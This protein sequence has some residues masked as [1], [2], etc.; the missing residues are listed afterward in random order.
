MRF[1]KGFAVALCFGLLACSD[2]VPSGDPQSGLKRDMRGYKASPGVLVAED[3]TPHWIQSAVT[4]YK[5]TTLDTDLPAKVVMQQPTAFC[6]FRKPNLG[7]YIGNVHVGT[8][9]MHAPIYTW[10]KTKIR[11][12]AQKL[13]E[14][15]QKPAD[16]PRKIR[17]DTMVLS[18]KD[19][20]FPV[21]DV[22]VTET[23][24]P[25][26]LILQNEFGKILWNIHL[27][28]GARISHVVALGVGDIAFAN[29]DPDVPV[30]MA[31]AR[32]L[33]SCGVQPWRKMQDHWLFA[34][35]AKENPSLHE[36][37]VAKNKAAYRKYDSWFKSAFGI[38][39]EQNLAGVERS[40]HVLVGP[41]PEDLDDR[42]PFRPLGG[43]LVIMTPVE[44]IAVAGKSGYEDK[45]MAQIRPLV[46][47]ALGRESTA[48]SNSGS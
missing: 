8:G 35:N 25:V 3:G 12:R 1:K 5:E 13:A 32:T 22:V 11:E 33:R 10:S 44:N 48:N 28:P 36:E 23:E 29:L 30:E 41:L 9:N 47:K 18:A 46:D 15:A 21:V 40:T 4:G 37:P 6:R 43:S 7:E 14:N 26:Y 34:R 27:A 24:K 31:G 38:R 16:D 39:S 42:I 20:S 45:A 19:D 2:N 17:V